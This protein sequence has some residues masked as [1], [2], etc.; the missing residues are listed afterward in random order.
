VEDIMQP[1]TVLAHLGLARA[2]ALQKKIAESRSAYGTF[3]ALFQEAAPDLP[4][5]ERAHREYLRLPPSS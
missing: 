4:I 3:L 5:L 1:R 2:Y